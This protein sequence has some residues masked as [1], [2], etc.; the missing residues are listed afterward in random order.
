MAGKR[1]LVEFV[2]AEP[3]SLELGRRLMTEVNALVDNYQEIRGIS[4]AGYDKQWR[5]WIRFS[6]GISRGKVQK[7]LENIFQTKAEAFHER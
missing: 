3:E 1:H 2:F 5:I 7:M 6:D 4:V